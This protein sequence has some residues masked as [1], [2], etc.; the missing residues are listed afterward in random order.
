MAAAPELYEGAVQSSG[1]SELDAMRHSL[2]HIPSGGWAAFSYS[3]SF[4]AFCF[5]PA[6]QPHRRQGSA[7]RRWLAAGAQIGRVLPP[8][9][10]ARIGFGAPILKRLPIFHLFLASSHF[11]FFRY[12]NSP[13]LFCVWVAV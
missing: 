2:A 13:Q 11:P 9:G 4:T 1:V 10:L 3:V 5:I 7:C 8:S 12:L 6:L